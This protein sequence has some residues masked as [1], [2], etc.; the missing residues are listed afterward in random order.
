MESLKLRFDLIW[1][2]FLDIYP[3]ENLQINTLLNLTTPIKDN[4]FKREL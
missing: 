4:K 3:L 1:K 2:Y